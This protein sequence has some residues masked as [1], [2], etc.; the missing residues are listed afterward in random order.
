MSG[1]VTYA[2]GPTPTMVNASQTSSSLEKVEPP[3][4][5]TVTVTPKVR[6]SHAKQAFHERINSSREFILEY[7]FFA[8]ETFFLFFV[9]LLWDITTMFRVFFRPSKAPKT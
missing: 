2:Q 7:N 6:S 8:K 5:A 1:A 3:E 4:H 9:I